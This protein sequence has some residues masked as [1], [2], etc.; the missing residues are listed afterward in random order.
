VSARGE[1]YDYACPAFAA[2]CTLVYD[3]TGLLTDYPGLAV[4]VGPP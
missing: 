2:R 3:A 4:R 1:A